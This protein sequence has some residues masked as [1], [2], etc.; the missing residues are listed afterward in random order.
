VTQKLDIVALRR[1]RDAGRL[2]AVDAENLLQAV[3]D[4][5]VEI[6]ALRQQLAQANARATLDARVAAALDENSRNAQ[7]ADG[8]VMLLA[9]VHQVALRLQA[10]TQS[11]A[12]HVS[13]RAQLSTGRAAQRAPKELPRLAAG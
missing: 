8:A 5:E 3:I 6:N 4:R 13:A 1:R 7:M 12:E 9:E 11:S 10:L 2:N